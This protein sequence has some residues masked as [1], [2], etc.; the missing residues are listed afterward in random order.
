MSKRCGGRRTRHPSAVVST[1][2]VTAPRSASTFASGT[3]A[4]SKLERRLRRKLT[5]SRDPPCPAS[6]SARVTCAGPASPPA[7]CSSSAV[8]R[9]S[10][11]AGRVGSTPRSKRCAASVNRP[12]RRARPATASG[13]KC[14][15][16]SNTSRVDSDIAVRRPPMMP[17]SPIAPVSSASPG[18]PD[19]ANT[20]CRRAASIARRPS[21]C[22]L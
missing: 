13:A 16:S 15:A 4:P 12:S 10:A 2:P 6:P 14:A 22:V 18:T 5:H 11:S 19:P 21:P 17:A 8:A 7:I 20:P 1:P 9:S 3:T